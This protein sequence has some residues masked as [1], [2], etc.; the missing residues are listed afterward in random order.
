MFRAD[1]FEITMP[2]GQVIYATNQQI[3][4]TWNGNTYYGSKF[5]AWER[6]KQTSVADFSL[7]SNSMTLTLTADTSISFPGTSTPFMSTIFSGILDAAPVIATTV[8]A[9]LLPPNVQGAESS[10]VGSMAL[11]SGCIVNVEQL[12]RSKAEL[13]VQ[14]WMYL[15]NLKVPVRVIQPGCPH[16]L[17]D[18]GCALSASAFAINNQAASG[19]GGVLVYPES[20]WPTT[21]HLGNSTASPY[22]VQGKIQW[23]SGQNSGLWG[24]VIAQASSYLQLAQAMPFPIAVGDS[25]NAYPGCDKL[26]STCANKFQNLVHFSGTPYT[27]PPEQAI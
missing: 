17:F 12:G 14:D 7:Q 18:T 10:I 27:P 23:L 4:V 1:L 21:D 16:V 2:N 11:F 13:T 15:L 20:G 19:S 26:Q 5:G 9:P 6:G 25:F 3:D 24:Y 22:F 8:Y